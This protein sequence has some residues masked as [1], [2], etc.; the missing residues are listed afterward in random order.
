LNSTASA[1]DVIIIGGGLSG[2]SAAVDLTARGHRILLLEQ[3]PFLGGRTYS[4]VDEV[5]GD[6]VDNGQHL[7]MGCYHE[8]RRYLRLIGS[9]HLATLQPNLRIDFLHPEKGPATL[10]CPPLPSPL[11]VLAGLLRLQ[12]LPLSDRLKIL[13]VGWELQ[14]LSSERERQLGSMTVDD[15]LS[16]LGQTPLNK[17]YLWDILAI[18]TL[19]DDPK[20]VSALLFYRVLKAAFL[21]T[22]EDSSLLIPKV[23]LSELLVDPAVRF[24]KEHGAEIRPVCGV[25]EILVEGQ[26]VRGVR[27]D[28]GSI[29]PAAAYISAVPY[30]ALQSLSFPSFQHSSELRGSSTPEPEGSSGIES[31]YSG[32]RHQAGFQRAELPQNTVIQ[33][34]SRFES[35]PIITIHLWLDRSIMGQEFVA[36][37]DSRVQWIFDKSKIFG[38]KGDRHYLSLVISGAAQYVAMEKDQLV[39]LAMED[40]RRVLPKAESARVIHSVVVKEKR[41][42]FSPKPEVEPHRP[43]AATGLKNFFL[44]GDWT[45]TG[46]PATIEGAVKSGRTAVEA[47]LHLL[48]PT[49]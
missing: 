42:T 12:S 17:K 2:L 13:R 36:L 25:K 3:R 35:S 29:V 48:E 37:L 5:T 8:T 24:L 33:A 40:L 34:L 15:W 46:Y 7:L 30:H 4:F 38:L 22:K 32:F 18:G 19:N 14:F 28:D 31:R 11:N 47:A 21:G 10:S 44:A 43:S 16:S 45:N 9:D 39:S 26:R 23:G 20:T 6:V 27:C 49:R 1:Y 41:A